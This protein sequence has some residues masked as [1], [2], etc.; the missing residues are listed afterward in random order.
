MG[1]HKGLDQPKTLALPHRDSGRGLSP[2]T[3]VLRVAGKAAV[4]KV[5]L[6]PLQD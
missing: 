5:N 1:K 6:R 2:A 4:G 3:V